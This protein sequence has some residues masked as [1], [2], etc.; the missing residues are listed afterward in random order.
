VL[1]TSPTNFEVGD[2]VEYLITLRG[3][4]SGGVVVRLRCMGKVLR[5]EATADNGSRIAA[6]LER[7]E[8]I[9]I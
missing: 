9:R 6:S 8:F 4:E 2:L 7:Y 3:T 5:L 1:F